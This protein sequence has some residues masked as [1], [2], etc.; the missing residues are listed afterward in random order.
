MTIEERIAALEKKLD[1]YHE[2]DDKKSRGDRFENMSIILWGFALSAV[3]LA[4]AVTPPTT[5]EKL[6]GVIV[7]GVAAILFSVL[8]I[9]ALFK[10][11]K[12]R[13]WRNFWGD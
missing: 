9:I 3:G 6:A 8:A 4:L 12:Y 2:Q 1:D 5:G 11:S 13:S 10:L 7:S